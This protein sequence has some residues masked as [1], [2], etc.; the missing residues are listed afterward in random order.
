MRELNDYIKFAPVTFI[1]PRSF[2]MGMAF[3]QT[4]ENPIK[5]RFLDFGLD[6]VEIAQWVIRVRDAYNLSYL[7]QMIHDWLVEEDWAPRDEEQFPETYFM[8]REN[9]NTGKEIWL[10]WRLTK[11]PSEAGKGSLFSYM[12]DLDWKIIG[13]KDTEIAWKGQKVKADRSEF[14]MTC[15]AALII[16]NEKEWKTWPFSSIKDMFTKRT[17]KGKVLMHKKIIYS[18][19]YRLRDLIM[20][21][22]KLETFMPVKEQGEMYLK[23]TLE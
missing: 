8:Q 22:L 10:R 15:R 14:E 19:A 7:Y 1:N 3:Q 17:M 11:K 21:Y 18:D 13:L 6:R 9:P 20:G 23:R 16:A 12:M 2:K 4:T 5:H